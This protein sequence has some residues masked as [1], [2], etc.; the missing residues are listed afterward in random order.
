MDASSAEGAD[1]ISEQ[2]SSHQGV[3]EVHVICPLQKLPGIKNYRLHRFAVGCGQKI[4]TADLGFQTYI[5]TGSPNGNAGIK[6]DFCG[7]GVIFDIPFIG[8]EGDGFREETARMDPIHQEK[9]S[10]SREFYTN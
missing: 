7:N 9:C 8:N 4:R 5:Q 3:M 10:I 1:I 6:D 2:I